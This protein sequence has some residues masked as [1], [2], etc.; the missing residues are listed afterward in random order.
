MEKICRAETVVKKIQ[1]NTKDINCPS[2]C[3]PPYSTLSGNLI[4]HWHTWNKT[5]PPAHPHFPPKTSLIVF[6]PDSYICRF[7]LQWSPLPLHSDNPCLVPVIIHTERRGYF[8]LAITAYHRHF[9]KNNFKR[10]IQTHHEVFP[11]CSL[12]AL[13]RCLHSFSHAVPSTWNVFLAPLH[14][15]NSCLYIKTQLKCL[16]LPDHFVSLMKH[17]DPTQNNGFKCIKYRG[18]IG[19]Q[20]C[21]NRIIKTFLHWL[22]VNIKNSLNK[23]Y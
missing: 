14:L 16:S 17:A 10:Y 19:N 6:L 4:L 9:P 7:P 8:I 18:Y 15:T 3:L 2:L 22:N 5:L 23:I 13:P 1:Q 21:W 11:Y 20:L 12:E